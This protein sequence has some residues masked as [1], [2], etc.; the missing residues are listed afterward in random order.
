MPT[1]YDN[2]ENKLSTGLNSH[3]ENAK[4]CDFCVGY[5]NLRGWKEIA[6]EID[7]LK[8]DNNVYCRLLIG[9]YKTPKNILKESYFSNNDLISNSKA[10][11]MKKQLLEE[12]KEQL[13]IGIPLNIDENGLKKLLNQLKEKKIIIKLHLSYLLHAKLYISYRS[14]KV[15]PVAGLLGS[16]NLTMSGLRSQGELNID[17]FDSDACNKLSKWFEERWEDRWSLD[18]TNAIIEIIEKS[19]IREDLIPYYIYLKIAYHLSF[20]AR[21][22]LNEFKIPKIFK[23][24]LLEFQ[25][26]SVLIGAHHL[27]KRNGVIIGDVVGLGKTITACA[28]A[29][30]F[31]EDLNYDTLIICPPN[32]I[33]MWENYCQTYSLRHKIIS[34]GNV[35]ILEDFKR[36]QLVIVDE[37]HN[38]RNNKGSR[39]LKIKEYVKKND[40]KVMLLTATPYNKSYIDISNQL[41]LF[42]D[43]DEDLGVRPE[44]FIANI[45]GEERFNLIH[46]GTFIR[47]LKAFEFSDYSEDWREL[48]RFYMVR[49][50][51]SFIKNNYAIT[52]EF[53]KKYLTFADGRKS[54]FPERIA[55]KVEFEFCDEND[56]YKKL[57]SENVVNIINE[58]HVPRYGL[59]NY[60][61]NVKKL[62]KTK[63]EQNILDDLS[64]A[65]KRLMGFC[66]TNLFK[67]LESSSYSFILS[68][69]RHI[70][71]NYLFIYAI[72]NNK[73]LPIGTEIIN[74]LDSFI[75][76][77]EDVENEELSL[78]IILNK[79]IYLSKSKEVYDKITASELKNKFKWINSKFFNNNLINHLESDSI[80]LIKVLDSVVPFDFNKDKKVDALLNL[81]NNEYSEEKVIIFTQYSDTAEYL[82][83]QL[84]KYNI[85]NIKYVTGNTDKISE[86]VKLFS[87]VSN[88]AVSDKNKEIRI[89]ITTD[90][91]SEG[92][93]LQDSHV[94]VN[95]DLP[96]AIIRLIQRVGRIDRIGQKS[97]K[98]YCYS[99]LPEKG[100][101]DIIKLRDKLNKRI[102]Q[103][104]EVVGSD[105]VFFEGN[106]INISDLYNENSGILEEEDDNDIDLSSYAYQIWK[107]AIDKDK[108]IEEIIKS[109]PNVAYSCKKSETNGV[110]VYTKTPR[111]NDILMWLDEGG[112][113]VSQSQFKILKKAECNLT[114]KSIEK[115]EQHNE[116][117]QK[118]FDYMLDYEKNMFG[119]LGRKNSTKYKIYT[120]LKTFYE[121]NKGNLFINMNILKEAI[122]DIYKY[123]LKENTKEIL[124]RILRI[125]A[126]DEE[127]AKVVIEFKENNKLCVI[128][129]EIEIA[130][131]KIIC[132]MGLINKIL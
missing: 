15:T 6:D 52:D 124:N 40:C 8:G 49:R 28:I 45:G 89:L 114:E 93:N 7:K 39:Y 66:R 63:E 33:D 129:E 86:I 104:A 126:Q 51:R 11:D 42:V 123:P 127:I 13:T 12:L 4:R 46:S 112:N 79:D 9:M 88:N 50:T 119:T 111:D 14:D 1:I 101:N 17:V 107:N 54:Y 97:D 21:E 131:P 70:L 38:L 55:K 94:V 25:Q 105:E 120:I 29:K 73:D 130:E 20:E 65:G 59:S 91:L 80:N 57:Y 99:F 10:N 34:M 78:N 35:K 47:S 32:L 96:W 128:Q 106:T 92:Q 5:F 84:E 100:L 53:G 125:K 2:L 115:T 102:Q 98:I 48:L 69:S 85:K 68:V 72:K 23:N 58:L 81:I 90:V 64:N 117:I 24:Q 62:V 26:K 118:S 77:D 75:T 113:I 82:F 41:S 19:W 121:E 108:N 30:I 31:E 71:R 61:K 95:Y 37:S 67:R 27:N 18:V 122:D 43:E 56:T 109:L 110:I 3:L 44:N 103:N 116:I 132:S 16:S 60:I 22:G 83:K 87:P 36:Y 76:E 74:F